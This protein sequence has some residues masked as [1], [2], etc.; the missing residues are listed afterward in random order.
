MPFHVFSVLSVTCLLATLWVFVHS[1]VGRVLQ[2]IRDNEQ[3]AKCLGYDTYRYK[4][5]SFVL[6]SALAG[7]A[8][9]LLAFLVRG[10]YAN[11]LS[12]QHA[13]DALLMA[14]LGGVHHFIGPLWGAI[15]FIVL[16]DQLSILTENWW[17]IFAPVIVGFVLLSSEGLQGA[18]LRWRGSHRRGLVRNDPP[19]RPMMIAPFR[20][21]GTQLD[22]AEAILS[23]RGLSKRFGS[24]VTANDISFD[25][26][27][28]RLHSLIGPNGAGKTTFF[29]MVSGLVRPDSGALIFRGQDIGQVPVHRRVRLGVARSFQIISLFS[30]LTAFETVRVAVQAHS[31]QRFRLFSDAHRL[32]EVQATTWSILSAVR[33]DGRADEVCSSLSHGEQRLLDL[34]LVLASSGDLLLLD[35]PLAGL[36]EADRQIVSAVVVDLARHVAVLM[37]EHD[38]DR[39]MALSDRITVLHGG[40][41]IADGVPRDV[42]NNPAVIA[43]Y[44]GHHEAAPAM[45]VTGNPPRPTGKSPASTP[46]LRLDRVRCGYAGST[47]L[48]DVSLSVGHGEVVALL[49][50]NGVGKTSTLRAITGSIPV[51]S[52]HIEFDGEPITG[53]PT[54]TITRRGIGLVPEGRRL[55]PNLTVAENLMIASRRG[56]GTFDEAYQLFPKLKL[57]AGS[58]AANLSGGERQM[59]AIARALMFPTKLI[60]LDEPFEGLAPAVV[61]EVMGAVTRLRERASIVIVEHNA[62]YVLPFA[63]RAY[64]LVSGQVAFEGSAERL[65]AEN[66]LRGKLLGVA[67]DEAGHPPDRTPESVL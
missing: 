10:A 11:N 58:R 55:F 3:R 8:G 41:L 54:Y 27:P 22:P 30:N 5:L 17:L 52:G 46:L 53:L 1:P 43:A 6:S 63:D 21:S 57:L 44:M 66:E 45:P 28:R 50:R 13:A 60:L 61:Q 59:L 51:T 37:I 62:E 14:V 18:F 31:L 7:Y 9:G 20:R 65:L 24:L 36:S 12:W 25:V 19:V 49:G 64:V 23:V 32:S 47:V 40:R 26:H 42:A 35:E 48:E 15:T 33:L 34:A 2:A 4:L 67:Y 38:I 16:K 56:G 29:N 39:V